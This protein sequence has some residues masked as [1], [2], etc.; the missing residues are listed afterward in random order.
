MRDV[1]YQSV[2]NP[3]QTDRLPVT[4][5]SIEFAPGAS[6]TDAWR[7]LL[8]VSS[9]SMIIGA[10][11]LLIYRV[12][13]FAWFDPYDLLI[14]VPVILTGLLIAVIQQRLEHVHHPFVMLAVGVMCLNHRMPWALQVLTIA[15]GSGLLVYQFGRHGAAMITAR[16]MRREPA[17]AARAVAADTLLILAGLTA[18]VVAA[19]LWFS[20][21]ILILAAC[22]LPIAMLCSPAPK[23]MRVGRWKLWLVSLKSW[24]SY[25]PQNLP[26]LLQSPAGSLFHRV[27]I[28][29]LAAEL[30]G[31]TLVSWNGSPL[32]GVFAMGA[33]HHATVN[34][35]L[36][37]ADAGPI[38]RIKHGAVTWFT[39]FAVM[40]ALPVLIPIILTTG[41]VTPVLCEAAAAAAK[42]RSGNPTQSI[43]AD[44]QSSPDLIERDSIYMGRVVSDGTPMLVPRKVFTEHAHGLGDSGSGKTSLFLCPIIEQLVMSGDCSVIVID[45]KADSL[46]LLATQIAAAE[47]LERE[48]GIRIPVK[49]FSNQADRATFA[50][51]PMTQSFWDNFDLLTRTDILCGANGLTYGTDYGAGY[52]SSANAAVLYYALKAFPHVRTFKELA[53]CI[54]TVI[55]TAKKQDLHPEIRKAGVHVQEV[56]K[57]LAN[58][59][60]LNV[61]DESGHD[62]EVVEQAIDLTRPFLEPQLLYFHLSATLSPSG[63]P[64]IGRL[65]NYILLA[66]STQ[67]ERKHQV[68]LVIDE[69]QRMVASNLEYMLQL[70]RSMGVGVILANQSVEDLKKSSVNLIPPIEANCRLRQWFSISCSEDRERLIKSSGETVDIEYGRK[71]DPMS[72][73]TVRHSYSESER[74]VPRI[75]MNDVLLT[76]DHPFRSFLKMSRGEGY[77]QYGGFPVTIESNYHITESEYRRRRAMPWPSLPGMLPPG[78]HTPRPKPVTSGASG[79]EMSEEL[80]GTNESQSANLTPDAIE[81]FLSELK[82]HFE[83][84][85]PRRNKGK[86]S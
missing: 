38:E 25:A 34:V 30:A 48:R 44:I 80:I 49:C 12:P 16:P 27:S 43:I 22:T 47:R 35:Q 53:E 3:L 7:I 33:E 82:E 40:A 52:F 28:L 76:S 14:A 64:E 61:T 85:K 86:Q 37:A 42:S 29:F 45:L 78:N 17:A 59:A 18:I 36:D 8:Q 62:A 23:E 83:P 1:Y 50:F 71:T 9:I 32:P 84:Q 24:Y 13:G 63:A 81:G 39:T 77:A 58:C 51:N 46:E 6:T 54:G 10:A 15:V 70:A 66:A 55:T 79:P 75:T 74:V 4:R 56:I 65:V 67:T 41:M 26:G 21:K 60:A 68:F 73:G 57:R 5:P 72:G 69:F 20:L 19:A 2:G 31:I 11:V